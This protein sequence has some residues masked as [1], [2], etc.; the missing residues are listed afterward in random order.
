MACAVPLPAV[1]SWWWWW[2]WWWW[3]SSDAGWCGELPFRSPPQQSPI[4]LNKPRASICSCLP[5]GNTTPA[6]SHPS[7]R[8]PVPSRPV[9][10]PSSPSTR[11]RSLNSNPLPVPPPYSLPLFIPLAASHTVDRPGS[12]SIPENT[13]VHRCLMGTRASSSLLEEEEVPAGGGGGARGEKGGA[14]SCQS[15]RRGC[16]GV[17]QKWERRGWS[18]AVSESTRNDHLGRSR[19]LSCISRRKDIEARSRPWPGDARSIPRNPSKVG[20]IVWAHVCCEEFHRARRE[21]TEEKSN[22]PS[23][24]RYRVRDGGTW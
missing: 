22:W 2:W 5:R 6:N 4:C 19:R 7:S 15:R 20:N 8:S 18:E 12:D 10:S 1:R 9:S 13:L 14:Q 3:W 23:R 21:R 11:R 16:T 24:T 17:N